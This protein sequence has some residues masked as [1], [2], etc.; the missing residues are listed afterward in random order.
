MKVFRYKG[1]VGSTEAVLEE[2][3][4]HGKLLYINDRITYEAVSI[5]ELEVEVQNYRDA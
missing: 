2:K 5:I 4:L 3:V 1:Y